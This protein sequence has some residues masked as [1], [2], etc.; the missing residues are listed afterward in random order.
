MSEISSGTTARVQLQTIVDALPALIAFVDADQRYRFVSAEYERWFGVARTEILGKRLAE[1]LGIP[2][3]GVIKPH[4]E[5]ALRGSIASYEAELPRPD[6]RRR[7]VKATYLP[8]RNADGTVSGFVV[9]AADMTEHK[10]LEMGRERDAARLREADDVARAARSHAEEL[11]RFAQ[12]VVLSESVEEVYDAALSAIENA[13]GARRA[14]V[15]TFDAQGVMRFRASHGLSEAYRTAIEGH[16]PWP[17]DVADPQPVLVVDATVDPTLSGHV[18]LLREESIAGLAF[19]P[20]VT[21]GRL[22]GKFMVYYEQPYALTTQEVETART[23]AN[24]LASA[25]ARFAA[26]EKLEETVRQNELFAAVLAHDLRNPLGAVLTAAKLVHA[27]S[28]RAGDASHSHDRAVGVILSSG[29][30]MAAMIDQL[31][32]FARARSGGGLELDPRPADLGDLLRDAVGELEVS[33]PDWTIRRQIRGDQR[34]AWDS[35]R[36]LQVISNLVGNAGR[37]GASGKPI[38][39]ALDGTDPGHVTLE[40]RNEGTIPEEL[41]P[42]LFEPFRT[43][44]HRSERAE[45]L[46]LGLFIVREIV[47]AHGGRVEVSS[48]GT[49]G[50]SFRIDLPRHAVGQPQPT[51]EPMSRPAPSLRA[52]RAPTRRDREVRKAPASV[53]VVDDDRDIREALTETLEDAGYATSTAVNGQDA[54]GV[55]RN[56]ASPPSAILLDLMMPVMDGYGFLAARRDEPDLAGIPVIV[57]TAGHGI[58]R[59]RLTDAAAIVPKPIKLPLLMTTLQQVAKARV[60]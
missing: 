14:A 4:V 50:T 40:V 3:Y 25:I 51:L 34:G 30:R 48:S 41:L 47:Q 15:L 16:S 26:V 9:F 60:T 44:Q 19:I 20:L 57:V 31:L 36:L 58:D 39:V 42:R 52:D 53:L 35:D 33:H 1:V 54:L 22:L 11:S 17:A 10:A 37:H 2:A 46:G 8:L 5:S 21:R 59:G 18:R 13:L 6:R 32:D 29:Q 43:T 49:A 28:E 27:R 24:Y 45:G 12:A 7:W 56:M 38:T 55:L 23:I